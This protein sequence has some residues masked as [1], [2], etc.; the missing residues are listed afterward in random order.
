MQPPKTIQGKR[1]SM[2]RRALL[3]RVGA[4]G[5]LIAIPSL[6]PACARQ[7]L[8]PM[9]PIDPPSSILSGEL[10][11]LVISER[12]FV[13]NGQ[14][15]TAMAINGTIP[16]PLIR[17]NE[18]QEVALRVTNRLPEITSIHWHGILLPPEVDGVP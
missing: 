5:L 15:G 1:D 3:K 6:F 9:A 18:G 12:S 4:L 10:I 7:R 17:L 14:T 2:S 16:G 13:L 11:D 8:L